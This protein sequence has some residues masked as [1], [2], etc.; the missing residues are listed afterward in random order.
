[1]IARLDLLH[2]KSIG[3]AP[4]PP[5][6]YRFG[7]F[8]GD[9]QVP[10]ES[11]HLGVPDPERPTTFSLNNTFSRPTAERPHSGELATAAS[12]KSMIPAIRIVAQTISV[13]C[14]RIEVR[15]ILTVTPRNPPSP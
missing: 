12:V 1:M 3:H 5:I 7:R 14:T 15:P 2:E 6:R 10:Q 8:G 13:L 4:V 11:D 9:V